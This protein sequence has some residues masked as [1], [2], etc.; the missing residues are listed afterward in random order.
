M[1][2]LA[3][4]FPPLHSKTK[5]DNA[6]VTNHQPINL[7]LSVLGPYHGYR[8]GL[9]SLSPQYAPSVFTSTL[10]EQKTLGDALD[11]EVE[12]MIIRL[13]HQR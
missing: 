9:F 11:N 6:G 2:T 10:V 7:V 13:S 1:P 5:K 3:P 12:K 4:C 8:Y